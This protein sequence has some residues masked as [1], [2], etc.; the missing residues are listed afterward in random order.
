MKII[1]DF[2][3]NNL[4]LAVIMLLI[5][6]TAGVQISGTDYGGMDNMVIYVT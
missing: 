2:V 1:E 4:I 3:I 6:G 5:V